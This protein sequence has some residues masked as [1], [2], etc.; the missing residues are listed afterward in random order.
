MKKKEVKNKSL[1]STINE[2]TQ[3]L[4]EELQGA[5]LTP[6]EKLALLKTLLPYS[7]SKLPTAAVNYEIYRGQ[8][9]S[10]RLIEVTEDGGE[11][12]TGW[13]VAL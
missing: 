3:R 11:F 9:L 12:K 10:S 5:E 1:R 4:I 7:V 2:I 13:D 8:P 6:L